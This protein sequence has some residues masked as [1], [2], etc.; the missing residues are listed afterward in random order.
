VTARAN[1]RPPAPRRPAG[2]PAQSAARAIFVCTASIRAAV[3]F[4]PLHRS[5]P[6]ALV[7]GGTAS[8]SGDAPMPH[9]GRLQARRS[10]R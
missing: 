9:Q 4:E 2:A 8:S 7:E 10:S 1:W 3:G 5:Q 6:P